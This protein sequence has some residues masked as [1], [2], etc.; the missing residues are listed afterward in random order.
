MKRF[1]RSRR[2]KAA[3]VALGVAGLLAPAAAAVAAFSASTATAPATFT[4]AGSYGTTGTWPSYDIRDASDG[5][6]STPPD[7]LSAADGDWYQ[8]GSG[9]PAAFDDARHVD[10]VFNAPLQPG[11]AV[12]SAAF[13][14]HFA[15]EGPF[16]SWLYV[17]VYR[18]STMTLLTSTPVG[19]P[20]FADPDDITVVTLPL[21]A[22]V[23]TAEVANDLLVRAVVQN[24]NSGPNDGLRI[25]QATLTGTTPLGAFSL[26]R[27]SVVDTAGPPLV[28]PWPLVAV[29]GTEYSPATPW[30]PAFSG[31]RY[32]RYVFP[33]PVPTGTPVTAVKLH[34]AFRPAAGGEVCYYF[35][36]LSDVGTVL[37]T[38]GST[39]S[40]Y[41]C[42]ATGA[43]QQDE[44][45]LPELVGSD[46]INGFQVR[47][48]WRTGGGSYESRSD[49]LAVEATY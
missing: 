48:Y 15:S 19:S 20:Y 41:S 22:F 47:M 29:D 4:S 14:M 31:S 40:P 5:S 2:A 32:V 13:E 23:P 8:T 36:V 17:E 1:L 7:S 38:H 26:G 21:D 9:F 10:F 11:L 45:V 39:A 18:R 25:D 24:D 35:D 16:N 33:S 43:V 3:V 49:R 44:I 46:A 37:G 34:H 42:N 30:T 12:T 28:R 27:E 6:E